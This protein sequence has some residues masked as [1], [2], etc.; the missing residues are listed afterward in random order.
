MAAGTEG[1][2]VGVCT[3]CVFSAMCYHSACAISSA[4][5]ANTRIARTTDNAENACTPLAVCMS[6]LFVSAE[7]ATVLGSRCTTPRATIGSMWHC[8]LSPL[9]QHYAVSGWAGACYRARRAGL[10]T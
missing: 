5:N 8:H 7:L 9:C 10:N 4:R 6:V 3:G 2:G 1:G